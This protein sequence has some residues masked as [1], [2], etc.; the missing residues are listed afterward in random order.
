MN[1]IFPEFSLPVKGQSRPKSVAFA[2][3]HTPYAR[4]CPTGHSAYSVQHTSTRSRLGDIQNKAMI[5]AILPK[6]RLDQ[7]LGAGMKNKMPEWQQRKSPRLSLTSRIPRLDQRKTGPNS[8]APQ[9][10]TGL[11]SP[12]LLPHSVTTG[13]LTKGTASL[14]TNK[15]GIPKPPPPPPLP[16]MKKGGP[17]RPPPAKTGTR[18]S[19]SG[20]V[21]VSASQYVASSSKRQLS[22]RP[23]TESS[24]HTPNIKKQKSEEALTPIYV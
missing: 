23:C 12:A 17:T 3:G 10:K 19:K 2:A 1:E 21:S 15:R 9:R 8:P 22:K 16:Q 6:L 5:Q 13:G 7:T 14:R 4:T 18:T 11:N 24:L 20:V